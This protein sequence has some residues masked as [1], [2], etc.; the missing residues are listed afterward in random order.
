MNKN[1]FPIVISLAALIVVAAIAFQA[2]KPATRAHATSRLGYKGMGDLH[3]FEA[4]QEQLAK[5]PQLGNPNTGESGNLGNYPSQYVGMGDLHRV[6]A[7]Q[8]NSALCAAS[9]SGNSAAVGMGDLRRFE[10][11]IAGK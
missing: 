10:G 9:L 7:A 11:C 1:R 8:K 2:F 5:Q 6:E 3:R 4:N